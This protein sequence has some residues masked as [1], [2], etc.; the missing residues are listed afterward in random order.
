MRH[1]CGL[2]LGITLLFAQPLSAETLQKATILKVTDGD[3]V[4]LVTNKTEIKLRLS[5]IDCFENKRNN[6][7]RWQAETYGLSEAEVLS[8]GHRSALILKKLLK[9]NEDFIFV[10][11][12]G[13]DAYRRRLGTLFI[14]RSNTILDVNQY[15]LTTGGCV[16][17]QPKP[18]NWRPKS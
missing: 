9:Q 3:T 7:I 2:A 5:K 1:F 6:R 18:R 17:Y 11:L 4:L 10:S 15:M 14:I 12:K 16:L 8:R 13:K